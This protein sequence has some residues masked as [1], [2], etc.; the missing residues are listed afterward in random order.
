MTDHAVLPA[1]CRGGMWRGATPAAVAEWACRP[2][3]PGA[4]GHRRQRSGACCFHV[5]VGAG[6]IGAGPPSM[7]LRG[8]NT[9]RRGCRACARHDVVTTTVPPA[10]YVS[11]YRD[12]PGHDDG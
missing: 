11:T 7:P 4:P 1:G 3:Y 12:T 8:F 10:H 5:M 2:C 6:P 9:A